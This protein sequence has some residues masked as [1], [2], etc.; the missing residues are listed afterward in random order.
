MNRIF[1]LLLLGKLDYER[2]GHV[3]A[4]AVARKHL[5]NR[6]PR[7]IPR[8][9][10][11]REQTRLAARHRPGAKRLVADAHARLAPATGDIEGRQIGHAQ[12]EVVLFGI[13]TH[14][15]RLRHHRNIALQARRLP[16]KI[17]RRRLNDQLCLAIFKLRR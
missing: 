8:K 7:H 6:A 17:V 2:A 13:D 15:R 3:A 11:Q 16:P 10:K 4:R 1:R 14:R 9:R 5:W 12:I